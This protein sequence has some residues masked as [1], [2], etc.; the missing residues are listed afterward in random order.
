MEGSGFGI[1]IQAVP[2]ASLPPRAA[3]IVFSVVVLSFLSFPFLLETLSPVLTGFH[4]PGRAARAAC[5]T[6]ALQPRSASLAPSLGELPAKLS[7]SADWVAK[8]PTLAD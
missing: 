1:Y 3:A 7:V 5:V 4:E 8:L 6:G 2:L